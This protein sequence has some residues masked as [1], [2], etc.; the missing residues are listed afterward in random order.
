M[1]LLPEAPPFCGFSSASAR[2]E[3]P[4]NLRQGAS[5][6]PAESSERAAAPSKSRMPRPLARPSREFCRPNPQSGRH[7]LQI[8]LVGLFVPAGLECR[9]LACRAGLCC[10]QVSAAF[11]PPL[12]APPGLSRRV[13][14]LRHALL[15]FI[16]RFCTPGTLFERKA[17]FALPILAAQA[18]NKAK[19]AP[20]CR[21]VRF[22]MLRVR[23]G[24]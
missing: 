24:R 3:N 9:L 12:G 18:F 6:W 17:R 23:R 20:K 14:L 1:A 8:A 10:L 22:T 2:L 13:K 11:G 15:P 4:Q 21:V 16:A 19:V 5:P 7:G